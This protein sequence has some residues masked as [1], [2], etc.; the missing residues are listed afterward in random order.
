MRQFYLAVTIVLALNMV[1]CI[2]QAI[3]GPTIQDTIISISILNTKTVAIMLLLSAFFGHE[4]YL[5][6]S[7][8]FAFLYFV[9]IYGVSRYVEGK[10]RGSL[11]N[12][13]K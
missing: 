13:D 5:D 7:F 9:V 4:M 10:G 8:V 12:L 2:Y 3:K 11:D 6:V 1:P